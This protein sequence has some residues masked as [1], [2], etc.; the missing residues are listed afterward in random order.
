MWQQPAHVADDRLEGA[1]DALFIRLRMFLL[2]SIY[3]SWGI[4]RP[5]WLPMS[6]R[7]RQPPTLQLSRCA[8]ARA[9]AW[10]PRPACCL[11]QFG[12]GELR[13][14]ILTRLFSHLFLPVHRRQSPV[15]PYPLSL[16]HNLA[17]ALTDLGTKLKL[18]GRLAEGVAAYERALAVCPRH[19]D[20]LYNMG[21]ACGGWQPHCART[22][23]YYPHAT[24]LH[25][26]TMPVA[27]DLHGVSAAAREALE[28]R[29]PPS[30]TLQASRASWTGQSSSTR[31]QLR[32]PR[33]AQ[34]PTTTWAS[35]TRCLKGSIEAH[36]CMSG[37]GGKG[38]CMHGV[39]ARRCK[40]QKLA[41][42][43]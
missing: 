10:A 17:I 40:L 39:A 35:F 3:R 24:L 41:W 30:M 6:G 8:R 11:H 36:A 34:R 20:A 16:Q 29:M 19:P 21:V 31:P 27:I 12:V 15:A 37:E 23:C 43:A 38:V 33:S 42:P 22:P 25:H 5:Q 4:W 1:T 32:C 18:A 28:E 26:L 2:S 14:R 7:L 9:W 13:L